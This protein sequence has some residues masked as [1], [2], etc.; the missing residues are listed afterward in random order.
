MYNVTLIPG[1]GIGPEIIESTIK[2]IEATDVNINWDKVICGEG[3]KEKKGTVCPDYVLE[4]CKKNKL[5]LKGPMI[6]PKGGSYVTTTW[7]MNG[8]LSTPVTY[9]TVNNTIR[10]ALGCNICLR[11]AKTFAGVPTKFNNVDIAVVRE[12]TEDIYVAAE[13]SIP[14]DWGVA[15]KVTTE[16]AVRK[17]CQFG[18]NYTKKNNR[19]K[20]TVIH[21]AN[22]LK[23]TDGLF[24]EVAEDVAKEYP[25]IEFDD[26]MIDAATAKLILHPEDFDVII[27]SN[28]YGDIISDVCAAIVGGLG[29]SGGENVGD[30]V[31]VYEASHGAAPDIAGQDKANPTAMMLSGVLLLKKLGEFQAVEKCEKAIE[32]TLKEG[33]FLTPD[34]GG[35]SSTSE[36]TN[37]VIEKITQMDQELP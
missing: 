6:V 1:D 34:I 36:Y 24:L 3:V 33:K 27:T 22:V 17:A 7:S 32:M 23:Q 35:N 19:K 25:E 10:R 26:L 16:K 13:Y 14:K 12:L 18:F 29:M 30:E 15:L 20:V 21:K 4:K 9:P 37:A 31:I 2:M 11:L 8:N 5:V 28:Q